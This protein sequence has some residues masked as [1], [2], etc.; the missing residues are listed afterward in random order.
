[1]V[2]CLEGVCEVIHWFSGSQE[3][4]FFFASPKLKL[5]YYTMSAV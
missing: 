1:M 3:R 4:H 2:N 5:T